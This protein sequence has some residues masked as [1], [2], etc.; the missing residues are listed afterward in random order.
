MWLKTSQIVFM[1]AIE[2]FSNLKLYILKIM[3]ADRFRRKSENAYDVK[4]G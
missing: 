2:S 3:L 4:Y 1:N